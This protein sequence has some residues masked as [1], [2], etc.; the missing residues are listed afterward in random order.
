MM[1]ESV[2]ERE[3]GRAPPLL[4]LMGVWH[5]VQTRP[6]FRETLDHDERLRFGGFDMSVSALYLADCVES[7]KL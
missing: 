4:E 5:V 3:P 2:E 7:G 1:I 6:Q